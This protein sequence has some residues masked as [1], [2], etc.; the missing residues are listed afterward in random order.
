[1][2]TKHL[3]ITKHTHTHTLY[4]THTQTHTHTL[5]KTHTYTHPHITKPPH[6]HTPTLYKTHTYTHPHITKL[7]ETTTVRD[8]HPI[9][10]HNTIKYPQYKVTLMCMILLSP[11]TSTW[12]LSIFKNCREKLKFRQ[13]RTRVQGTSHDNQYA[14]FSIT[15]LFPCRMKNV[16]DKILEK[17][18][19]QIL[20]LITFSPK[21]VFFM[22]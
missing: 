17:I 16:S 21:I 8:T 19:R 7:V 20:S 1:M 4:K 11:R 2:L 14:Y 6:I 5:Y 10:R 22:K 12:Y 9:K 15:R 13:N 18:E 3:H